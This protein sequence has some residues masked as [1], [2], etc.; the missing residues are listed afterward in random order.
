MLEVR[1]G[2]ESGQKVAGEEIR[3]PERCMRH[4]YTSVVFFPSP[5]G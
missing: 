1:E 5:E 2:S 4:P 3:A